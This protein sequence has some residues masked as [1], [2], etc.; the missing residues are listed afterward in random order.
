MTIIVSDT[1][2]INVVALAKSL[3]WHQLHS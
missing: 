3:A 2:T 1:C